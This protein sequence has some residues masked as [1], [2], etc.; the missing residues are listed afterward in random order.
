VTSVSQ[1]LARNG[2]DPASERRCEQIRHRL[3]NL[4]AVNFY[5]EGDLFRVVNR[6]NGVG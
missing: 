6:L 1:R 4:L 5:K 3:P 2:P